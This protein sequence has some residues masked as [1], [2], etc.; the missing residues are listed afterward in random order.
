M[1]SATDQACL[2]LVRRTAPSRRPRL[3]EVSPVD[4]HRA[5][6]HSP[7]DWQESERIRDTVLESFRLR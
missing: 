4:G 6:A 3:A 1:T 5:V 2:A 7:N